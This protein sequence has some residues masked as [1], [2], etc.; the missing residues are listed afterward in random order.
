[1]CTLRKLFSLIYDKFVCIQ[2]ILI[3]FLTV[4]T[5]KKSFLI[6]DFIK[7]SKNLINTANNFFK[8]N[9]PVHEFIKLFKDLINAANI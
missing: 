4:I 9:L 7:I 5:L 6:H 1:M 8:L 2:N 3:V